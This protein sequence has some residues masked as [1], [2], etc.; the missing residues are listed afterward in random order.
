MTPLNF[1]F[2]LFL[3]GI[4]SK[5]LCAEKDALRR[6]DYESYS[7]PINHD[8]LLISLDSVYSKQDIPLS[9]ILSNHLDSFRDEVMKEHWHLKCW[10][11]IKNSIPKVDPILVIETYTEYEQYRV[12]LICR[13]G[14]RFYL[15]NWSVDVI[16]GRQ[17]IDKR[18]RIDGLIRKEEI[19]MSKYDSCRVFLDS[20]LK[21]DALS[22]IPDIQNPLVGDSISVVIIEPTS[23]AFVTYCSE[24]K[25]QKSIAI[26]NVLGELFLGDA[27]ELCNFLEYFRAPRGKKR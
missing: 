21:C 7:F 25:V 22:S 12:D 20:I 4:Y 9:K 13:S 6:L 14:N 17:R 2:L 5:G 11:D 27:V 16:E 1:L 10:K 19:K 8:S 26:N 3:L 18:R 15:L 24:P 23:L